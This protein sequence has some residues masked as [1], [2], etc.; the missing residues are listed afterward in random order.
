VDDL[1]AVCCHACGHDAATHVGG[2]ASKSRVTQCGTCRGFY[3]GNCGPH[4]KAAQLFR[5]VGQKGKRQPK[6]GSQLWQCP[7]CDK[8]T[9]KTRED[10]RKEEQLRRAEQQRQR[11]C[12]ADAAAKR[13][14]AA[15]APSKMLNVGAPPFVTAAERSLAAA[16]AAASRGG[17]A[18]CCRR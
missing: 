18:Q 1:D 2:A 12:E 13:R 11:Q 16:A 8:T 5:R 14:P 9:G 6:S 17:A 3:R 4:D 10:L 7:L 15:A